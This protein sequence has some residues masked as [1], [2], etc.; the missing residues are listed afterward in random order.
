VARATCLIA[1]HTGFVL[2]A[3]SPNPA[4]GQNYQSPSSRRLGVVDNIVTNEWTPPV[5]RL[6]DT[7]LR[8]ESGSAAVMVALSLVVILGIM[9]LAIDVGQLRLTK[10]NLQM[11]ADA[12]ALAGALELNT[13]G[14][15]PDCAAMEAAAKAALTE[16][17]FTASTVQTGCIPTGTGL[18]ITIN[19]GPCALGTANPHNGNTSYVEVVVSQN[20]PTYFAGVLGISSVNIKTRAEAARSGGSNCMFA[21]DPNGAG[22]ITVGFLA[23]LYSPK[24]GIVDESSSSSALT[25]LLGSITGSQIGVVGGYLNIWCP[26]SSPAPITGIAVP[27][28]ADPLDYLPTP[29]VPS[30][31]TSKNSPYNG[32]ASALTL[33]GSSGA[34]TLY[35]GA[36]CGGI[37][38]G[39]GANVTFMPGTYVLTSWNGTKTI[40]PGGLTMDLG[41][42][43][44]GSGVTFYNYGSPSNSN[45]GGIT[46]NFTS[47]TSGGVN[48]TAPTSGTYSGILFFQDPQNIS[49]STIMGTSS[50]NTVLQGIYYFPSA[51]VQFVFD[52]FVSYSVLVAKDISFLLLT[53]GSNIIQTGANNNNDFSSLSNGSPLSGSGAVL[54]Q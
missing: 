42:T 32:S 25:C 24:C 30:C 35:P 44:T 47:F 11:A 36:Y 45:G 1:G 16:N 50:W 34:V 2:R 27:N 23:A 26:T 9:G 17:G 3:T 8:C 19:N 31:G 22:A 21:L 37:T 43:V 29:P 51:P 49:T 52:G 38:I 28:P 18:A 20:Q 6:W 13:C 10:Q 48:L 4:A 33:T 39:F 5:A 46:F 40:S 54:V 41:A 12:A 15:T 7:F 53:V 14:S